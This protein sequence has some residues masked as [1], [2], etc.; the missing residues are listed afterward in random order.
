MPLGQV[1]ATLGYVD[2]ATLDRELKLYDLERKTEILTS[3]D[4]NND[5]SCED[6]A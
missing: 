3:G 1:L 2:P 6:D 4:P 5:A